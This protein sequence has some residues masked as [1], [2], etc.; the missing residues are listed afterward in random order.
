MG[1]GMEFD[2]FA[3]QYENIM[4][5]SV[6]ISGE[7][8]DYFAEYKALYLQRLFTPAY[9]GKVLDYGCGVGM[10]SAFIRQHLP[11]T[12]IDGFDVSNE[13]ILRI[14][15]ALANQGTFTSSAS[16]LAADYSLIV[17]ANVMHHIPPEQRQNVI[18]GL[19]ARLAPGGI[20]AIFEH[21]P[22]N[23][24]TRWVVERC[25][26]DGDA[27]L[28]P[29]AETF[30]I[31]TRAKLDFKRR[32]YIVFM[33]RLLGWLRAVEPSLAWLP[34][35]AQYAMVAQKQIGSEG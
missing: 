30:S 22:V 6:A 29:P 2:H 17:I 5:R 26:F 1:F 34:L 7:D 4:N 16:E 27:I 15:P 28:L 33:P 20:I 19:A 24:V 14:P 13:S 8:A 10:L 3:D 25:P 18:D 9:A 23:P 11:A 12:H 35:G 31:L 32:D 21:N